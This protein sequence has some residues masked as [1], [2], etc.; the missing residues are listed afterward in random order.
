MR[1]KDVNPEKCPHL[2][3]ALRRAEVRYIDDG[4][5]RVTELRRTGQDG[6]AA[7]LTRKLLG[8]KGPPMSD[9]QKEERRRYNEEHKEERKEKAKQKREIRR[10]TITLL[11]TGRRV[12]R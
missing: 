2:Y 11:T 6:A 8:V 7:R 4:W 5:A 12:R 10:R 9:E 3:A 1:S